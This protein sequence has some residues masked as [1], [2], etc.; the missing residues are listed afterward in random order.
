MK[1]LMSIR[2]QLFALTAIA[3]SA[4]LFSSCLKNNNDNN[5]DVSAAGLMAFNLAPNKSAIGFSLSGNSLTSTAL[6]YTNY[7][8]NYLGVYTGTRSI[9]AFDANTN[10]S[11]TSTEATFDKDKYYSLFLVGDTAYKNVV[12]SDNIDSLSGTSGVAYVRYINAIPDSSNP[13]V[14]LTQGG[15]NVV[16]EN[17]AFSNV[18]H[19]TPF[20]AGDIT[21]AVNNNG[22]IQASRN[23][24]LEQRKVYTALLIG[25]PG[26]TDTAKA[27]KIK[28]IENGTLSADSTTQG[29]SKA[30]PKVI[31][32]H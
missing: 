28:Y 14:T 32:I 11:I 17:A 13:I 2:K 10:S 23:I 8:G 7:T 27:V 18:S 24:T 31:S 20:T 22:G 25:I 6:A 12:V 16:N 3:F 26:S 29:F 9:T 21:I 30:S 19:F 15:N 4:V 1:N 5:N